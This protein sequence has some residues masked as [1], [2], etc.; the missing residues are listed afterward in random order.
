MTTEYRRTV[1]GER[2]KVYITDRDDYGKLLDRL[3]A[4]DDL[5]SYDVE[6]APHLRVLTDDGLTVNG[7]IQSSR[8][9]S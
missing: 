8:E 5:A 4:V 3:I 7:K 1:L 6:L 9:T 2:R